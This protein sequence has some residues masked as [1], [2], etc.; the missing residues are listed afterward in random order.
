MHALFHKS[1]SKK[2]A[3]ERY[4]RERN[5][6][7]IEFPLFTTTRWFSRAECAVVLAQNLHVLIPFLEAQIAEARN[8]NTKF[9]GKA[10][11]ILPKLKSYM[12]ISTVFLMRDILVPT[13]ILSKSL[14][15]DKLLP[16]DQTGEV[17]HTKA[18]LTAMCITEGIDMNLA[19]NLNYFITNVSPDYVWS[20]STPGKPS[21]NVEIILSNNNN[22]NKR[23]L[24]P[25]SMPPAGDEHAKLKT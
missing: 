19:K 10:K 24:T 2:G 15:S 4:A 3:W 6:T 13:E 11:A 1:S 17:E 16:H 18:T 20:P 25:K 12:N 5:V 21:E 22:N 7:R 8:N 23:P 9:W 14:Q